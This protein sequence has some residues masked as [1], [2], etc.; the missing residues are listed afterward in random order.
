M[1]DLV[2]AAVASGKTSLSQVLGEL[3]PQIDPPRRFGFVGR[4]AAQLAAETTPHAELERPW[5]QV[6][7]ELEVEE[8]LLPRR[9]HA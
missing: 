4:I 2:R 7:G 3:L 6:P 1:E 9:G 8:W 5:V